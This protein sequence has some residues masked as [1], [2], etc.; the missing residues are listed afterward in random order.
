MFIVEIMFAVMRKE[1]RLIKDKNK[2]MNKVFI[3]IFPKIRNNGIERVNR[4]STDAGSMKTKPLRK[5]IKKITERNTLSKKVLFNISLLNSEGL[6]F[7]W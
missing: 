7:M 3:L 4:Y 1:K 6:A 5:M 2:K